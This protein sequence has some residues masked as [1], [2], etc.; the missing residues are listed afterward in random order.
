MSQPNVLQ[1]AQN[2]VITDS[3]IN[4]ANAINYYTS[5]GNRTIYAMIPIKPNSSIHFIGRTNVLAKL[6]K[7]FTAESNDKLRH[8]K[9]F[10]LY[11]MGGIWKTQICLRFIEDMSD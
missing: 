4:V 1:G 7:H 3:N 10:L 5:T 6:K 8:Q 11:G 2:I 9:F